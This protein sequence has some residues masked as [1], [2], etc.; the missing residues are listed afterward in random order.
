MGREVKRVALDFNWPLHKVWEGFQNPL[1]TSVECSCGGS[2]YSPYANHLNDEWYGMGDSDFRPSDMNSKEFGSDHPVVLALAKRNVEGSIASGY[3]ENKNVQRQIHDEARRLCYQCFD[4]HWCHH[5]CQADVDALIAEGRLID[6]THNWSRETGWQPKDPM[7]VITAA[8][9]N[10]WSLSGF[11]HDSINSGVCIE[12]R[13]KREGKEYLCDKC[14]GHGHIW[15][16]EAEREA[17]ENWEQVEP[18]TGEGY[19][20]WEPVSEGSPVSPVFATPEELATWLVKNDDSAT[21][22][23]TYEEWVHFIKDVGWACSA[24]G[25]GSQLQSGVKAF[26]HIEK[27]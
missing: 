9:V 25:T 22:D 24:V 19:Q 18:P 8:E 16:S 10:A 20:L 4:N 17:Y 7:P 3:R 12:Y 23:T 2:G 21:R 15:P 11:G 5:L 6:F 1:D 27:D 14:K 13:C 26:S